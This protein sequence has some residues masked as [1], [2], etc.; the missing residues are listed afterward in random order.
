VRILFAGTPEF[1]AVALHALIAAQHEIVALLTQPDRPAGRGMQLQPS[2]VKQ[3]AL[4]NNLLVLQP[5]TLRDENIQQTLKEYQA[6]VMIVAAYGLILPQAI[7]DIPKF[8]CLNIHASLLPRWRGAAPIHR[9]ILAGDTQ[10]G[11][12]IMKM[13]A[14]LDTGAMLLQKTIDISPEDTTGTLHDRLSNLGGELMVEA[15]EKF[16]R[17]QPTSQPEAGITY[18]AKIHKEEARIDWHKSAEEIDRHIRAFNPAPGTVTEINGNVIKIWRAKIVQR[19]TDKTGGTII[20]LSED[21]IEVQCGKNSLRL[22]VLQK[23]GGKKLLANEFLRGFNLAI[24]DQY[25]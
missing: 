17:L 6:D 24:G 4:E 1:A 25:K 10:T 3:V 20:G 16:V 14:G 15:L 8:G 19:Q 22:L 12:T 7:L 23:S 2:A 9:A 18:A 5:Q 11:I 13:D 21:G